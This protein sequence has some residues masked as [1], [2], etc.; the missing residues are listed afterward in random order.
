MRDVI[1]MHDMVRQEFADYFRYVER[2]KRQVDKDGFMRC[3][4]SGRISWLGWHAGI[5]DVANRPIQGG[6]RP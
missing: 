6:L 2:N 3:A 1:R 5:S 4:L